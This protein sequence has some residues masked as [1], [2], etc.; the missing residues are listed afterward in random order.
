M[1]RRRMLKNATAA[2]VIAGLLPEVRGAP[3]LAQ[4]T[5]FPE[6]P[7]T[8]IVPLPAGT[9]VDIWLRALAEVASKSLGQPVVVD[10][11]A[12]GSGTA[13]PA[14]MAATAKP[15]G[16]TISVIGASVFRFPFMQKTTWDPLKDFTY[17]I[18]MSGYTFGVMV[19]TD[20][21]FKSLGDLV[22]FAR[23]NPGKLTY[24]SPGA[25]SA[26]HLGMEQIAMHASVKFTHVPFK[27]GPENWAALEGGHI[28][29]SADG[30]GAAPMVDAGKFRLLVLW[31]AERNSRWPEVPTLKEAGFNWV[32]D[33]PFGIGGPR[34]MDPAIVQRLHDAFKAALDDAKVIVLA[35]TYGF[36][37]RYLGPEDYRQFVVNQMAIE[38]DLVKRLGLA[39]KD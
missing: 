31:T 15:D 38:K 22:E 32:Y 39:R 17:I 29:A 10:N 14:T 25:G 26:L 2:I 24:G 16:S 23:A 7:I 13:G 6:K 35:K 5:K 3:A 36:P 33:S 4:P 30:V 12:G 19:R 18:H 1:H 34:G 21:P 27:G 28:M 8:L 37:S 20:S 9:G 11:R